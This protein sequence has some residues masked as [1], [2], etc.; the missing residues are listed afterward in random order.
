MS[1]YQEAFAQ[2][3]AGLA[4]LADGGEWQAANPALCRLLGR[5]P[6]ELCGVRAHE[7]V[8]DAGTAGRIEAALARGEGLADLEVDARRNGPWRLSL[9]RLRG[10]TRGWLLQ[11]DAEDD[12]SA[13]AVAARMLEHLSYGI[14]HDLRA[15]LRGIAG[16]A[17]RLDD[18]GAVSEAGK[19]DLARIRAAAAR[20]E[21][22]ADGL[23]E[24]LRAARQPLRR[25]PVDVSL[26]FEWV[27]GDLQD[28]NPGRAARIQVMPALL[29]HGD[30]HWL[31]TLFGHVLDNA[32]KFSAIRDCVEIRVE[33]TAS[34][35]RLLLEVHDTGCGFDMRYADKLF[36]PFQ[37]LH[38][39]EQGGGNG[40]GLSIAHQIAER[41]GGRIWGTS[42]AGEGSTFFIDLPAAA[43]LELDEP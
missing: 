19:G 18:S 42:R 9:A 34:D 38:G 43:G 22:L 14:S 39:S 6:D 24:L 29:A 27:A 30:E 16:F 32:W 13:R 5:Q 25:G 17:A 26:L 1:L 12:D 7:T 35:G 10:P 23:L 36:L 15:P 8:F 4:L 28:A 40:L 31:K 33:G 3:K 37:R 2:A 20:A 21:R 11:L 41:H